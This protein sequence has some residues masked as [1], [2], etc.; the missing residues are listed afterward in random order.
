MAD[1]SSTGISRRGLL[2]A[3]AATAITAAPTFTNAAGF[4][5]GAGDIRRLRMVSPRTGERLDTIYWVE[6]DYIP[7]ALNEIT[8]FMRDWR[9]DQTRVID[10]RTV[11]IMA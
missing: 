4:L 5:R 10:R 8:L 6:G 2:A 7:E 9:T 3:F 1:F 11:D